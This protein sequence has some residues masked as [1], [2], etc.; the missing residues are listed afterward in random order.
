VLDGASAAAALFPRVRGTRP[1]PR[2]P[3][4]YVYAS[5]IADYRAEY[6]EDPTAT[7]FSAH[8][9]DAAWLVLYGSAWSLLQDRGL[10][11]VGIARGMRHLSDGARTPVIPA[12]WPTVVNAFRDG[13][14]VDVSGAS[15]ELDFDPRTR[16]VTAPLEVWTVSGVPPRIGRAPAN[17][18]PDLS[19]QN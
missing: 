2:D 12:S 3:N 11:S 7:A 14:S 5:F 4:E 6:A 18:P 19:P 15:G 13:R 17:V 16:E 1:A 9:Y 8:S 10:S